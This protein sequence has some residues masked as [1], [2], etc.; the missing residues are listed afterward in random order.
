MLWEHIGGFIHAVCQHWW[1]LLMGAVSGGLS[2]WEKWREKPIPRRVFVAGLGIAFTVACFLAWQ[3]ERLIIEKLHLDRISLSPS[4]LIRVF[5]GRTTA[6]GDELASVYL[7]KWI[8][9][10]GVISD[11]STYRGFKS[12]TASVFLTD[13]KPYIFLLFEEQWLN[14]LKAL[15]AG[16]KIKAFGQIQSVDRASI[17][18]E[19][20]EIVE[21]QGRIMASPTPILSLPPFPSPT[22]K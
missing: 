16:D 11:I 21:F 3:D 15:Q 19:N 17:R 22:P 10:S 6:Q 5:D 9:I 4:E 13:T 12:T 7:G 1:I 8:E 18:I 2:L 14:R 20:S